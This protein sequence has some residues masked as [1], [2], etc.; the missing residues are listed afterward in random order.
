M[1]HFCQ[2]IFSVYFYKNCNYK[3]AEFK[4]EIIFFLLLELSKILAG[5]LFTDNKS[6]S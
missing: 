3:I 1:N 2:N 5:D 6:Q 4:S